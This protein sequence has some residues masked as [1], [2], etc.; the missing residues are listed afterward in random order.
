MITGFSYE[1]STG[2]WFVDYQ[3]TNKWVFKPLYKNSLGYLIKVGKK[4]IY[5]TDE[6][7]I[8]FKE[9]RKQTLKQL[10]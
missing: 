6:Q 8:Q 2:K 4:E 1:T 3:T 5:L 7:I 9:Q 10:A